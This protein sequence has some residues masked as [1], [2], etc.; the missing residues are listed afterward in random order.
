MQY[1]WCTDA[2]DGSLADNQTDKTPHIHPQFRR[3]SW[4]LARG[5]GIKWSQGWS[6]F[7]KWGRRSVSRV[8]NKLEQCHISKLVSNFLYKSS[9][10]DE[11]TIRHNDF[12]PSTYLVPGVAS[13]ERND[14]NRPGM[15]S[16]SLFS[17]G[18]S[19]LQTSDLP[20]SANKVRWT[21]LLPAVNFFS[22]IWVFSGVSTL[23][24]PA[25]NTTLLGVFV[26]FFF[27]LSSVEG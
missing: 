20:V 22:I 23:K 7:R 5:S 10:M 21:I 15:Y 12:P 24:N 19:S 8:K 27:L 4:H 2:C 18:V 11:A 26:A 9:L 17:I 25:S 13:H 6:D 14:Q 1:E 16:I 3:Q